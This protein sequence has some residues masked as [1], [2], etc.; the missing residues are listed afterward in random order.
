[1]MDARQGSSA[2]SLTW[3]YNWNV[4]QKTQYQPNGLKLKT[5][6]NFC[7][8]KLRPQKIKACFYNLQ[9]QQ[10]F[11]VKYAWSCGCIEI[12]KSSIC[13]QSNSSIWLYVVFLEM[14]KNGDCYLHF[15]KWMIK[16]LRSYSE[17][18]FSVDKSLEGKKRW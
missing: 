14:I 10:K 16:T 2:N 4:T 8:T 7:C 1:M 11:S 17:S 18:N 3:C 9:L 13:W 5:V 15:H 12:L 6:L